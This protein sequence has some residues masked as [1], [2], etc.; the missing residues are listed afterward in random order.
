MWGEFG[1][2]LGFQLFDKAGKA[3]GLFG[4]SGFAQ[5]GDVGARKRLSEAFPPEIGWDAVVQ[6]FDVEPRGRDGGVAMGGGR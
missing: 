4:V 1:F 6:G 5:G 2:E 3:E